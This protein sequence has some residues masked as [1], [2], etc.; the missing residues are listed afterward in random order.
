MKAANELQAGL[1]LI[2]AVVLFVAGI[3]LLGQERHL[4][5]RQVEYFAYFRDVQGLAEGAPVRLG[6][7]TIGR[8]A[9]IEFAPDVNDPKIQVSLLIGSEQ[10]ERIRKDSQ[11]LI[12]TQ[13]LL[14]DKYL[15]IMP[16]TDKEELKPGAIIKS[17]EIGDVTSIMEKASL[18]VD[19]TVEIMTSINKFL[20]KIETGTFDHLHDSLEGL[21][22]ILANVREGKGLVHNIIYSEQDSVDIL[23]NVEN[24]T[25]DLDQLVGEVRGGKGLLHALIYDATGTETLTALNSGARGLAAAADE[26]TALAGQIKTGTGL[27]HDLFYSS[28]PEELAE[29]VAKLNATADNLKKASE[30]LASGSG[31]LGAL[32]IDA[33]LYDNLVEV[34]DG[35]KRSIILR[36]A[37]R[38]SME[39]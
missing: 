34:T 36:E 38:S 28:A 19:N 35:A 18:V 17:R 21:A 32:L 13:G 10:T 16:G 11:A 25:T 7:I 14:G 39:K 23:K 37:I 33:Q 1:F 5:S 31:T 9:K 26:I 4:F 24:I 22:D 8:V 2:L 12:M 29:V 20:E 3:Y 15:N 6:G 30:A 27:M